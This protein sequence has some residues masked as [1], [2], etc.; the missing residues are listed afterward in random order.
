MSDENESRRKIKNFHRVKC[1][2]CKCIGELRISGREVLLFPKEVP[3]T[4]SILT[5]KEDLRA[6]IAYKESPSKKFALLDQ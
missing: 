4:R 1:L 6:P 5:T 2:D 3:E